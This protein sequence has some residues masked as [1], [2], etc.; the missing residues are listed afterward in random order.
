M[1]LL[2]AILRAGGA[3][4]TFSTNRRYS[5]LEWAGIVRRFS[6]L[7][8]YTLP[9]AP[10]GYAVVLCGAAINTV[11]PMQSISLINALSE[12]EPRV[13]RQLVSAQKIAE[14][15]TVILSSI[16]EQSES[17]EAIQYGNDHREP[18]SPD[19]YEEWS[20]ESER[21]I[22]RAT[23]F[24]EWSGGEES[25]ALLDL[26]QLHESVERPPHPDEYEADEPEQSPS[27]SSSTYWTP[28]ENLRGSVNPATCRC[29][30]LRSAV[31]DHVESISHRP[32]LRKTHTLNQLTYHSEASLVSS[33]RDSTPLFIPLFRGIAF[34]RSQIIV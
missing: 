31:D 25:E 15:S 11:Q 22:Q 10:L 20:N 16:R 17:G 6:E 30:P 18:V 32:F 34:G 2:E 29:Q 26:R 4:D 12:V 8:L 9:P 21:M 27:F 33:A 24:Y 28:R 23:E 5:L 13:V 19:D 3:P 14:W 7:S 1:R